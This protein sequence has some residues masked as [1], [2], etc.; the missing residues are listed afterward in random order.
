MPGTEVNSNFIQIS[1]NLRHKNIH[2]RERK[3]STNSRDEQEV[4]VQSL[5]PGKSYHF[6]VVSNSNHGQGESSEIL[7]ISTQPEEN[8]AGAPEN[9]QV[10]ALSHNEIYLKWDPPKVSNG[11]ILKYRVFYAE[12][13]NGDDQFADTTSVEFMLT[14]LRAYCE[15]TVS[16]VTINQNGI[17]NP[18]EEKLVKTFSDTPSEPP[19]NITLEASSSTVIYSIIQNRFDSNLFNFIHQS[20]I[21]RWE[22]PPEEERNGPLTGYKIKYR[23]AK[24]S[25]QQTETTPGNVK[26]YELNNL[27]RMSS[28]QIKIAAMTVNGTGPFTDWTNIETY[29]NDLDESQVPGEPGWIRSKPSADTIMISWGS[30]IQ[31]DIK[32]RA[33]VLGWGKGYPDEVT[34]ELDENSRSFEIRDLEPNS[35][36][37]IALRARNNIGDGPPKYDNTRTREDIMTEFSQPLEVPVGLRAIPT[38]GSSIV[39]YWTDTTLGKSQHVKDNRF[40]TVRYSTT[41]STKYRFHNTTDLN[42]MIGD[43]K[44]NTQY[45]FE[46]KVVKGRRESLWSMS[47]LNSTQSAA[48][49]SPPRELNVKNLDDKTPLSVYLNWLPPKHV[50]GPIS[51]YVILYTTD[52]DKRDREWASE[53]VPSDKTS[54]IINQLK[55]HTTYYFK[56]Q[57]KH[58][59]SVGPFSA[60]VS[61]T[62]GAAAVG[63][64]EAT[65]ASNV[66]LTT[67]IFYALVGGIV[68]LV[69]IIIIVS[70]IICCRR[71]PQETPEHKKS[72][73]QNSAGIIKPPDL[74]IHHEQMELKNIE[75]INIHQTTPGCSD[76]ASSSGV[77]TLPRSVGHDFETESQFPAHVTNS[78]DKRTYVPGYM[79]KSRLYFGIYCSMVLIKN[80]FAANSMSSSASDRPQYPRTQYNIQRPHISTM[81]PSSSQ[82]NIQ[83]G[84]MIHSPDNPYAYDVVPANYR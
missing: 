15:Y 79:S 34:H 37:V 58:G 4:N 66:L 50:L 82:Q 65:K 12:G 73:Q 70:L 60:M 28:Y 47:V 69:V 59:K 25:G 84:S 7:E 29:E 76:G 8:I 45:E 68:L 67:E 11:V 30:P 48:P 43:L 38:S 46:V 3:I 24:K 5:L 71:K 17:G 18:T 52:S 20:I 74:W 41:G 57:S 54:V 39:V 23:K 75:K 49:A 64:N 2:Y 9:L 19:S 36:Y 10:A 63:S 83:N 55:P 6:R 51:N 44:S 16:V 40:Y 53:N 26:F 56:V 78:L 22:P 21:I 42:C 77:M 14:Q 31:Q 32:V 61:H 35:E 72:Y 33:Y 13:E 62:T 80:I 27:D 1:N 81:D